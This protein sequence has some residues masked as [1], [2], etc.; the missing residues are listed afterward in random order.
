MGRSS[1]PNIRQ[2]YT[3]LD[4]L[5]V[6]AE[7]TQTCNGDAGNL[8]SFAV[9]MLNSRTA[10]CFVEILFLLFLAISTGTSCLVSI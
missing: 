6:A 9:C 2:S 8:S 7:E 5:A 3:F 10:T 1:N 4:R